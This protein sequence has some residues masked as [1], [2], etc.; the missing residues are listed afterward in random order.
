M[1]HQPRPF[2]C[3]SSSGVVT[4]LGNQFICDCRMRWLIGRRLPYE[5]TPTCAVP[6][7]LA[8][9]SVHHV[10]FRDFRC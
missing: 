3:V 9:K 1:I 5:F 4:T 6:K 2:Y 7:S 8:G 10:D